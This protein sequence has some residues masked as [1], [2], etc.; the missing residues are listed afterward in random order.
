MINTDDRLPMTFFQ[1]HSLSCRCRTTHQ[2]ELAGIYSRFDWVYDYLMQQSGSLV[3]RGRQPVV[4]GELNNQP[5]PGKNPS[6][7]RVAGKYYARSF[8]KPQTI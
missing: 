2:V 7:W 1:K 5:V 6:S 3:F 4:K 8:F